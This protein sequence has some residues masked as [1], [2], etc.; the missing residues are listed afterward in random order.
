MAVVQE[1]EDLVI[2]DEGL[3]QGFDVVIRRLICHLNK[4][5]AAS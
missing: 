2:T 3:N 5:Q 1:N 4:T